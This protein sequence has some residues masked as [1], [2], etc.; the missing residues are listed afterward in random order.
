VRNRGSAAC[1]VAQKDAHRLLGAVAL[2]DK[3]IDVAFLF[4][5]AR[6]FQLQL[7]RRNIDPGMLGRDRIPNS[8]QHVGNRIS[9]SFTTPKKVASG[10]LN[11]WFVDSMNQ[12]FKETILYQLD[13]TTPGICPVSAS[14]RKQI[15]HK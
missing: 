2:D 7:G 1:V 6:N 15:R 14:S 13:F 9:H 11:H 8:R 3:V 10:R 5:D 12:R 4:E